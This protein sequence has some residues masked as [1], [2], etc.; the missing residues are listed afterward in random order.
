MRGTRRKT[1]TPT[2]WLGARSWILA[3]ATGLLLFLAL[4]ATPGTMARSQGARG[5]AI[6]HKRGTGA[7][8]SLDMMSPT[9]GWSWGPGIVVHTVDGGATLVD[10]TPAGVNSAHPVS[11]ETALDA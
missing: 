10:V 5:L 6:A 9:S 2:R 8:D 11:A 4:A 1:M 7:V 3:I